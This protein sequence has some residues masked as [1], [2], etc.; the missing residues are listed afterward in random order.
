MVHLALGVAVVEDLVPG[1][2][3]HAHQG[4]LS[5]REDI[6]PHT[7]LGG[8]AQQREAAV[9]FDCKVFF[10]IRKGPVVGADVLPQAGLGGNIK[11]RALLICQGNAVHILNEEMIVAK[12]K[13]G[14][15]SEHNYS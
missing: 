11:R 12:G 3:G 6:C 9:G 2:A 5:R 14:F 1:N 15:W 7:L 8:D 10:R 4:K 13:M